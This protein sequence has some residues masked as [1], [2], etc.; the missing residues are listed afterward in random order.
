MV[1][2]NVDLVL[3]ID[4]EGLSV[5]FMHVLVNIIEPQGV[6]KPFRTQQTGSV[7]RYVVSKSRGETD[8]GKLS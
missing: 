1:S 6:E 2:V 5:D 7:V 4:V 8:F 3:F